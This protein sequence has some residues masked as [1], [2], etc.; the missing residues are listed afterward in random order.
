M[1]FEFYLLVCQVQEDT[2]LVLWQPV[3]DGMGFSH[4]TPKEVFVSV[5]QNYQ[6]EIGAR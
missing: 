6:H 3:G 5:C 2:L 4:S 1:K